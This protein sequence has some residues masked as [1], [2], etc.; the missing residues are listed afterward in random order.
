MEDSLKTEIETGQSPGVQRKIGKLKHKIWDLERQARRE[1][2]GYN[3]KAS[4]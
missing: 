1:M 4:A 2:L 3:N